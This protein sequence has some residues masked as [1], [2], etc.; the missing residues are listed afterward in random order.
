LTE[1]V[2]MMRLKYKIQAVKYLLQ[3][4]FLIFDRIKETI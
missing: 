4:G 2:R 3:L 1:I